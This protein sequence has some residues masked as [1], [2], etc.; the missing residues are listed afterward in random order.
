MSDWGDKMR[1]QE[2]NREI[3][4]TMSK[5]Y[6]ALYEFTKHFHVFLEQLCESAPLQR[7][8]GTV[9]ALREVCLGPLG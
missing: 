7:R 5:M 2:K 1:T 4:V 8:P 6:V 9:R 3:I